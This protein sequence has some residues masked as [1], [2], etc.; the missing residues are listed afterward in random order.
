MCA[1]IPGIE[2]I[3]SRN[4]YIVRDRR[5]REPGK[6]LCRSEGDVDDSHPVIFAIWTSDEF[7][8]PF[9]RLHAR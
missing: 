5:L 1:L 3:L 9:D 4:F 8:R 7:N 2:H 6:W